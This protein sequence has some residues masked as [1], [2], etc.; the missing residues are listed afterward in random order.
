MEQAA[1]SK[2]LPAAPS[3]LSRLN[4]LASLDMDSLARHQLF[5]ACLSSKPVVKSQVA[6]ASIN[7]PVQTVTQSMVPNAVQSLDYTCSCT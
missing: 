4:A 6:E 3:L 5:P 7:I 1:T 2:P